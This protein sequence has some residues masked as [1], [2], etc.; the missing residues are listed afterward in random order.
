M[1]RDDNGVATL[2]DY[3]RNVAKGGTNDPL[4]P[5]LFTPLEEDLKLKYRLGSLIVC[6]IQLSTVQCQ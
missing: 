3:W 4:A 2:E 6:I 5:P 1:I